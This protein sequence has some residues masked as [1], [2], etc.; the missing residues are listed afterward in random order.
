MTD[1]AARDRF[2]TVTTDSVSYDGFGHLRR[3]RP[4]TVRQIWVSTTNLA[5]YDEFGWLQQIRTIT[6]DVACYNK[7]DRV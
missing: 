4:I 2:G 1:L 6:T 3:I 5:G 7:F